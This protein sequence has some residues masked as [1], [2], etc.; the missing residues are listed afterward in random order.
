MIDFEF[1]SDNRDGSL[2]VP[3][4]MVE[5]DAITGAVQ[6]YCQ[7]DL[8][9]MLQPPFGVGIDALVVAYMASAEISCF[10][11]L[12]WTGPCNLVDLYV[13]FRNIT[14]GLPV[15][16]GNG[17][18]G[19]A[20][21]F[22]LPHMDAGAKDAMRDLILGGGP[23]T[24]PEIQEILDYCE[25]DVATTAALL[26]VMTPLIDWPRALLRGRYMKTVAAI[27]ACGIPLDAGEYQRIQEGGAALRTRLI[28]EVDQTYQVF[29]NGSFSAADFEA[30][31]SRQ[32]IRGWPRLASGRLDLQDDTFREMC[33]RYP[34][35]NDM[36]ELRS[37]LAQ[38]REC[39]LAIGG[40]ARNRYSLRPFSAKTGRNQPSTT[41]CIFGPATWLRGLI[42]PELGMGLAY[43]DWSQQEFGIAAAF[44]G[45]RNMQEAYMSGDPYL[46]FAKQAGAVPGTATKA[47]HPNE[48]AQYKLCALGVQY[49]MEAEGMSR[50]HGMPLAVA[51]SL[52][53]A[54]RR[55]YAQF[56]K[57]SDGV[58]DC[59]MLTGRL[60]TVFG[61]ELQ[62]GRD[63]NARS[64]RNWPM[65]ANG[66]EMLRLACVLLHERGVSVCAPVHDAVLI[67]APLGELDEAIRIT[68]A[69]MAEASRI[70][71]NGFELVTDVTVVRHPGRYMDERG[72]SMWDRVMRLLDELSADGGCNA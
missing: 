59:A 16:A 58:V 63:A 68:Q 53:A 25:A 7:D 26:N 52:L 61:W 8:R 57:W 31:L 12:G 3:V 40:D 39:K 70:I 21:Y 2:P 56:W 14:N 48:R 22:G 28:S 5:L 29:R 51:Q 69:T 62:V 10:E 41:R 4:A 18:L 13:E 23:W 60:W 66:A 15:P 65:Q 71:L 36:K 6:R 43:V 1:H 37:S 64:L 11:V 20:S 44:S 47:S 42:K 9:A 46:T 33:G 30:Y 55:T 45:D 35:V 24:S 50:R 19:A 38:L 72:A 49:G 54:H 67:E 34:Q 27:E 17:L 32:N